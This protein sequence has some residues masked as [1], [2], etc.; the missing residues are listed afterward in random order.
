MP[1]K[2]INIKLPE[3]LVALIDEYI[4]DHRQELKLLGR[5]SRAY[6]VKQAVIEFLKERGLLNK[7]R[8]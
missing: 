5:D 6:V 7:K 1:R 3:E 4:E 8:P 2:Y